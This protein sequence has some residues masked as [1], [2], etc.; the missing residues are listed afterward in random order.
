MTLS[1][2]KNIPLR[3]SLVTVLSKT[4]PIIAVSTEG[5]M[6]IPSFTNPSSFKC[7]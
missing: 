1:V 7:V 6:Y 3:I 5:G 4:I 2:S